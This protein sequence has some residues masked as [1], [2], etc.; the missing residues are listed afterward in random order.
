MVLVAWVRAAIRISGAGE[1]R[2]WMLWCS[3]ALAVV[4]EALGGL[5]DLEGLAHGLGLGRLAGDGRQVEGGE[6]HG[7]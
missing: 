2:P 7:R 3:A 4:A 5:G 6:D 1:P